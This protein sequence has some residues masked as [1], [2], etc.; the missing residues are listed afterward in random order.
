VK[1]GFER[2]AP[3]PQVR[4]LEA[5]LDARARGENGPLPLLVAGSTAPEDETLVLKRGKPCAPKFR[6]HC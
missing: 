2:A 4:E 6:A 1:F 5:W 3:P